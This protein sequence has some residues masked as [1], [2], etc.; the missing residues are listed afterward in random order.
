[1]PNDLYNYHL[2]QLLQKEIIEKRDDGYRLTSVGQQYVAD[3]HHTSDQAGRLFKINVIT[4]VLRRTVGGI[5]VLNQRRTANPS[6]GKIGVMSGTIRKNEPLLAGATRKLQEETGLQA[7]FTLAGLERRIMQRQSE[8]F[9]DVMFPICYTD[10]A[11]GELINTE[12]GENFWVGIEEAIRH[13]QDPHDSIPGI[14]TVLEAIRDR[15]I[16]DLPLFYHE[17]YQQKE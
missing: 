5:E 9:S 3:I 16:T 1:M 6:Y 4:I 2:K 14:V 13:E 11:T 12:Y 17:S 8:L 10:S 7:A 15:T